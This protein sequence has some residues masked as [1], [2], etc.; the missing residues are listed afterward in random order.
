MERVKELWELAQALRSIAVRSKGQPAIHKKALDLAQQVKVTQP[1]KKEPRLS[2]RGSDR[3][4]RSRGPE[5]DGIA[6]FARTF[7]L[8]AVAAVRTLRGRALDCA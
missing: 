7:A 4:A 1:C 5:P 8:R 6:P 2:R 3:A